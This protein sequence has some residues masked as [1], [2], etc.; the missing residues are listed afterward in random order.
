[1][2]RNR[3]IALVCF[4]IAFLSAWLLLKCDDTE[5]APVKDPKE[6]RGKINPGDVNS[7]VWRKIEK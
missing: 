4:I 1:M 6:Q 2:S 7:V 3:K 5:Q